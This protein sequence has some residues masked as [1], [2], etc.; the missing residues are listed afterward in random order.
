[1]SPQ[2][3]AVPPIPWPNLPENIYFPIKLKE[4]V[5]QSYNLFFIFRMN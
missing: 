2:N 3:N 4:I 5:Q 1:M